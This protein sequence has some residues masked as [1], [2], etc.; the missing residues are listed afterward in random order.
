MGSTKKLHFSKGLGVGSLRV[1]EC[2][3]KEQ[4][5]N[6]RTDVAHHLMGIIVFFISP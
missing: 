3:E 1:W 2:E 4:A 6:I 5:V